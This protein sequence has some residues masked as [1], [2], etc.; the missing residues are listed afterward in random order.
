MIILSDLRG[1]RR[2]P[3]AEG[4]G[5]VRSAHQRCTRAAQNI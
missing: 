1:C 2:G 5:P 4:S 3:A